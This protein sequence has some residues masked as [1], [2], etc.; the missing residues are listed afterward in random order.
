L[1]NWKTAYART[2]PQRIDGRESGRKAFAKKE[3]KGYWEGICGTGM[4]RERE[5]G[6]D[7]GSG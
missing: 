4:K 1:W 5:D 7:T 2:V 3:M 6:L